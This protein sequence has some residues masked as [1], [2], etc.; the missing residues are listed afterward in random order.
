LNAA[1]RL[2]DAEQVGDVFKTVKR[3]FKRQ[4]PVAALARRIGVFEAANGLLFVSLLSKERAVK[5]AILQKGCNDFIDAV[6]GFK[7]IKANEFEPAGAKIKFIV[8]ANFSLTRISPEIKPAQRIF[9][10]QADRRAE[11]YLAAF[12]ILLLIGQVKI[13]NRAAFGPP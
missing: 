1:K 4:L 6:A 9:I 5:T 10:W 2:I 3:P 11:T 12:K 8:T 7:I 13:G